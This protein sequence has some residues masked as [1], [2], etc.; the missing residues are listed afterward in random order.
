MQTPDNGSNHLGYFAY[1][2]T[3]NIQHGFLPGIGL[4]VVMLVVMKADGKAGVTVAGKI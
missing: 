1:L 4:Y 2:I 3:N